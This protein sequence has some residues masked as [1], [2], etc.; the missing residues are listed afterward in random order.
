MSFGAD[1]IDDRFHL[2]Y[3]GKVATDSPSAD[4]PPVVTESALTAPPQRA[5]EIFLEGRRSRFDELITLLRVM[6]R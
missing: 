1:V 5:D 4:L 3:F 6:L 2:T